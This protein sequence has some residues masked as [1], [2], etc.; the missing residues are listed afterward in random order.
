[1]MGLFR[2]RQTGVSAQPRVLPHGQRVYAVGDVHGCFDLLDDLLGQIVADD[3]ARGDAQTQL[4]FLGDLVDRGPDSAGVIERLIELA[5]TRGN[6]RFILG[7]HEEIFLRALGGDIE[8]LR[9][10]VRIGGRETILSYGISERDY[11]R[12]DYPELLALMQAHVPQNHLEFLGGFE[13]RIEIG[14][15]VFVHAG[16]RPGTPIDEQRK[17]DLRWIRSSFLDSDWNFGK[18]VVHGHSISDDVVMRVNR[19]GIDTGAYESGR[20]TALGIEGGE[21]WLLT[22]DAAPQSAA[23]AG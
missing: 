9:L 12:T 7:N 1:M 22:T 6:V 5:A 17:S 19:I 13:D 21:R 16:M 11:E 23:A 18:M 8:S 20:L 4:I 14:D 3:A 10:F 2:K 15:Y